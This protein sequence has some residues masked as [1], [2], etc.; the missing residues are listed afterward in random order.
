M[1]FSLSKLFDWYGRIT[2]T[3]GCGLWGYC[4]LFLR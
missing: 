4:L 1:R 3:I 2:F